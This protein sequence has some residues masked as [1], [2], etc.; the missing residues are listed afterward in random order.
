M[1]EAGAEQLGISDTAMLR[2]TVLVQALCA[3]VRH[4][5]QIGSLGSNPSLKYDALRSVT[6]W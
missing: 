1:D 3:E 6:E 4:R 2:D 5:A